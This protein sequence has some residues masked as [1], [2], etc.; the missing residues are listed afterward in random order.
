MA[1]QFTATNGSSARGELVQQAGGELLAGAGL[2][3][4]Q[5]RKIAC[6]IRLE[7]VLDTPHRFLDMSLSAPV[8]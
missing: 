6:G 8:A 5:H 7:G 3:G 1:A 4:D 2:A